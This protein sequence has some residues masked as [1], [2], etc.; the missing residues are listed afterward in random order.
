MICC[1]VG[2]DVRVARGL[3]LSIGDLGILV[4]A[5][6]LG[7]LIQ[8]IKVHLANQ[9]QSSK[10]RGRPYHVVYNGQVV[11]VQII[12]CVALRIAYFDHDIPRS[13]CSNLRMSCDRT[14]RCRCSGLNFGS[15][16]SSKLSEAVIITSL[17]SLLPVSSK[18]LTLSFVRTKRGPRYLL[19]IR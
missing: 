7:R 8:H 16:R 9:S 19:A 4:I 15:N 2:S 6:E 1:P 11:L 13:D 12:A 17:P 14:H 5:S 10:I 18:S 3:G